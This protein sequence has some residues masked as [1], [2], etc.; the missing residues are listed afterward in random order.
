MKRKLVQQG[1]STMMVSLP[2]KWVK[3]NGLGKGSEVE[4]SESNQSLIISRDS[5]SSG[6]TA[7]VDVSGWSP[8]IN[9]VL[10]SYF[11][12]GYDEV[13]IHYSDNEQIKRFQK[14]VLTTELLGWEIIKQKP[15]VLVVKDLAGSELGDIESVIERLMYMINNMCS[16]LIEGLEKKHD[17]GVI[18][19]DKVINRLAYYCLRLLNKKGWKDSDKTPQVYSIITIIEELGDLFKQLAKKKFKIMASDLVALKEIK[20]SLELFKQAFEKFDQ[21]TEI[22]IGLN[23]EKIKKNIHPKS[24]IDTYLYSINGK[25]IIMNN[26]LIIMNV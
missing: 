26:E 7:K 18:E 13:E 22:K 8:L 14:E 2:S 1:T 23:Y 19:T 11:L 21:Q 20:N 25:I 16:E 10:L 3:Q 4:L 9:R 15:G 17:L 5:A 12:R 6:K 24:E